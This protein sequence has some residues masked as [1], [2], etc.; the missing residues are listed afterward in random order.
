MST[1]AFI[2][3]F[4]VLTVHYLGA[5]NSRGSRVKIKSDRFKQSITIPYD[6]SFNGTLEI[7][8]NWLESNG[9]VIIGKG[10]MKDCYAIISDTFKPLKGE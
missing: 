9:F 4:H 5:T 1:S 8:Q 6:H 3:N 10:E 7:G 2:P